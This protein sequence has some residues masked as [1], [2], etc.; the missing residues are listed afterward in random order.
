MPV[1]VIE[2]LKL[3]SCRPGASALRA[4]LNAGWLEVMTAPTDTPELKLVLDPGEAEAI[5]LAEKIA[6]RFLLI[7]ERRGRTIARCCGQITDT[8]LSCI[9]LRFEFHRTGIVEIGMLALAVVEHFDVVDHIG[10]DLLTG[11]VEI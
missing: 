3:D 10:L 2:E 6:C 5:L 11:G 8:F 4:A 7:D 1:A 9:R